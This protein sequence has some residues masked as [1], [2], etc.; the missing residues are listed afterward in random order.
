MA[1]ELSTSDLTILILGATGYTGQFLLQHLLSSSCK[2]PITAI[3][4]VYHDS[5]TVTEAVKNEKLHWHALDLASANVKVEASELLRKTCPTAIVNVAALS[6]ASQ[7]EKNK[8]LGWK[9][10][11]PKEFVDACLELETVPSFIHF[12]TDI[13]FAGTGEYLYEST[14]PVPVN[15][16]GRAKLAFDSFLMSN[17]PS[18]KLLILRASNILGPPPPYD[19]SKVKFLQW[20]HQEL[21]DDNPKYLSDDWTPIKLFSDEIR[22]YVSVFDL[23]EG[24]TMAIQV[25]A[26]ATRNHISGNL[27]FAGGPEALTRVQ[28]AE[29]MSS[30][31]GYS[32][33]VRDSSG[34]DRPKYQI[35]ARK[36]VSLGYESPLQIIMDTNKFEKLL[37]RR[38]ITVDKTLEHL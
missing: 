2:L 17:M 37:G 26:S 7:C 27:L 9:I 30:F 34:I 16:Y 15:E 19:P 8:E 4:G 3:H 12:S 14:E 5:T 23:V 18:S 1:K 28:I 6:S 32:S 10:N 24:I 36:K 13:V 21:R 29:K 11:C 25:L 38:P 33:T 31:F 20:L 35:F 22:C